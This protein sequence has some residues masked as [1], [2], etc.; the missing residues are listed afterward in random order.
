[1]LNEEIFD[2]SILVVAHPDDEVLWFSS[3]IDKVDEILVCYL[4]FDSKP[5]WTKGREL[6]L[7]EYPVKRISSLRMHTAEIFYDV[8]WQNPILTK[9]GLKVAN[10]N[11]SSR[12]YRNNYQKLLGFLKE[13]LT[14]YKNVFSHNPWGE[15]GHP[16]HIQVHNV[17]NELKKEANFCVWYPNYVSNKSLNLMTQYL[18]CFDTEIITLKTNNILAQRIK[19]LYQKHLCWTWY[20]EWQWPIEE[21]LIQDKSL[22]NGTKEYGRTLPLN[23]I[24]VEDPPRRRAEGFISKLLGKIFPKC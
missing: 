10:L 12:R 18:P 17:V 21:S 16:E 6:A 19:H 14:N 11:K 23:L 22:R 20:D 2:N 1:M 9:Y 3:V 13:K 5:K 15:Y 24:R 7:I 4:Y 8:D